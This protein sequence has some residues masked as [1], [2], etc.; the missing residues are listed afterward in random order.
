MVGLP[1]RVAAYA[2]ELGYEGDV[3]VP[4]MW[5]AWSCIEQE[6]RDGEPLADIVYA[7]V[8]DMVLDLRGT[9]EQAR[10]AASLAEVAV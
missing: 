1:D 10:R 9:V 7:Y 3:V 6:L 5:R 4:E 8:H 2:D